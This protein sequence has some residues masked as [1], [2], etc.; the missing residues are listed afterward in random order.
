MFQRFY[1]KFSDEQSVLREK[2]RELE[3]SDEKEI[4]LSLEKIR[5]LVT[6]FLNA[7]EYSKEL[8]VSLIERI[9][10]AEKKKF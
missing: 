2:I 1:Q 6:Q 3:N 8:L 5:E 9:E 4:E 10:L 7:E